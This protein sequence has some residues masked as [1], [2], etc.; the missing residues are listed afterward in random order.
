MNKGSS[1]PTAIAALVVIAICFVGFMYIKDNVNMKRES[2][3]EAEAKEIGE[4][5]RIK[6]SIA[7][8][9]YYAKLE[10]NKTAKSFLENLPLSI[11]MKDDNNYSKKGYAYVKFVST[12]RKLKKVKAGDIVLSGE[13]VVV[14][15]FKDCNTNDKYSI[16]GHIDNID[17]IE[18][19]ELRIGFSEVGK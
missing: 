8:K 6:V 13:S 1:V 18:E 11:D 9:V 17:Y 16:I 4:L 12:A 14:V 10:S 15:F 5:P 19:K 3:K 2:A 7:G